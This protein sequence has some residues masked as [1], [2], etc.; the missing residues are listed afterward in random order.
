MV[1]E[2]W[3][4]IAEHVEAGCSFSGGRLT[5]EAILDAAEKSEMQ[6]F[7][8]LR[9]ETEIVGVGVTTLSVYPSGLKCC[10]VLIV[11]GAS[12]GLWADMQH[13]LTRW[14]KGEGCQRIQ[15]VGRKGWGKT[16]PDWRVAATMY[17]REI[18]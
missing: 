5:P 11:G 3:P 12:A 17:E 9:N 1:R 13:P 16:L 14:A 7:L 15:M 6:V 10:D 18:A 8:A 4:V 2:F